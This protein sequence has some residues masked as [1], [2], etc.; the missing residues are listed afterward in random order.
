FHNSFF[1]FNCPLSK[2]FQE[3]KKWIGL[4]CR[5]LVEK[6]V[7]DWFIGRLEN[8][9]PASLPYDAHYSIG[10]SIDGYII[11]FNLPAQQFVLTVDLKKPIK[12]SNE[13]SKTSTQ[14][15]ILCQLSSYALALTTDSNQLIHLPTF[16]DLNSFYSITS[17][18]SYQRK[19]Q[20]NITSLTPYISEEYNYIILPCQS[21]KSS[22]EIYQSNEIQSVTI[23]DVLPKQLNVK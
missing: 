8:G 9:L 2:V 15:T 3:T 16:S 11:D 4:K 5:Y 14:C 1:I 18:T 21:R 22:I 19:Q 20:V 23:V 17:S 7:D 12:Y 6:R 13:L 10:E